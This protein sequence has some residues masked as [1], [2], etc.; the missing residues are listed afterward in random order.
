MSA[1]TE[2]TRP[3]LQVGGLYQLQGELVR[4]EA[5]PGGEEHRRSRW[6]G[7]RWVE[8]VC[9]C[10]RGVVFSEH[11]REGRQQEACLL[12]FV[13]QTKPVQRLTPKQQLI[14]EHLDMAQD[15]RD[16]LS[17]DGSSAGVSVSMIRMRP[18]S[19]PVAQLHL[20]SEDLRELH[21]RLMSGQQG[22]LQSLLDS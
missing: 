11:L 2:S 16:L 3:R 12:E 10:G 21:R 20:T 15:I 1:N 4:V 22:G 18:H 9:R 17:N 5:L 8:G 13:G 19:H 7:E 14:R 6:D